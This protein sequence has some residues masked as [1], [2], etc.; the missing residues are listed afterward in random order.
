MDAS[1]EGEEGVDQQREGGKYKAQKNK[2]TQGNHQEGMYDK[3]SD[4][5]TMHPLG[6]D[7]M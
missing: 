4:N 6:D 1:A 5:C 3:Q 7:G 2:R